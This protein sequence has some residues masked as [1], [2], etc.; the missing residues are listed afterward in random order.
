MVQPEVA[1][2]RDRV[3]GIVHEHQVVYSLRQLRLVGVL[4]V[5]FFLGRVLVLVGMGLDPSPIQRLAGLS[6]LS[7]WL[8]LLPLGISLYLLGGGRRRHRREHI[9]I[10]L[11]HASLVPLGL[12]CALGLPWLTFQENL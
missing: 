11:L 2:A 6:N 9:V 12:V 8:P 10:D 3:D 5:L 7:S 1:D 4:L